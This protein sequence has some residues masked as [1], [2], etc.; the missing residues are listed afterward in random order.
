[1]SRLAEVGVE[2]QSLRYDCALPDLMHESVAQGPTRQAMRHSCDRRTGRNRWKN[3]SC[4]AFMRVVHADQQVQS[5]GIMLDRMPAETATSC[6]SQV[7]V[8]Q[9]IVIEIAVHK[10]EHTR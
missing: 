3:E 9:R 7:E 10:P 2:E 5:S 4:V 8:L 1:M 6:G